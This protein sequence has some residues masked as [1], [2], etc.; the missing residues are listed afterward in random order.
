VTLPSVAKGL[1]Y[2]GLLATIMSTLSSLMFISATTIGNDIAGRIFRG[3]GRQDVVRRWTKAG[4]VIGGAVAV[5][6]ALAVPSV[7]SLWY[8][9]GTTIIPGLLVPI[10][11]GYFENLRI[12][13]RYA[14]AAM[15]GGWLTSSGSLV[16][17]QLNGVNG[18]PSYWFGIEPMYPGLTVALLCWGMGRVRML[19]RR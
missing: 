18:V 14:F 13:S 3:E 12:S 10:L 6:L 4:L 11:A 8:T 5:G 1:F 2:V 17:G 15:L 19:T 9:I 16:Y 7:V